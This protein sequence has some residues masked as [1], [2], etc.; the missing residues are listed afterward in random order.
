MLIG[1][2]PGIAASMMGKRLDLTRDPNE[3]KILAKHADYF[4]M[5]TLSPVT[6]FAFGLL[7][8]MVAKLK[9]GSTRVSLT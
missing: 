5:T 3:K 4:K 8:R 6:K 9:L 2:M 7:G 1:H